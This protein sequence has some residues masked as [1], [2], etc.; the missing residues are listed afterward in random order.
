MAGEDA[1]DR[2]ARFER[3]LGQSSDAGGGGRLAED[4]F[5][6]RELEPRGR[7]LFVGD[8]DDLCAARRDDRVDLP[9]V[10]GFGD[11]DRLGEGGRAL[12]CLATDQP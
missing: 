3:D 4:A 5:A 11:A 10:R 1:D 2:A 9:G 12:R 6:L 8:R 7:D